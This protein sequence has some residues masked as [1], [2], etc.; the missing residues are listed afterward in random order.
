MHAV[1]ASFADPQL[2]EVLLRQ[3]TDHALLLIDARGRVLSWLMG[4][5]RVFGYSAA[6]MCGSRIDRLY[7][8]EDRARN[9]PAA[10]L[11]IALKSGRSENDRWML[12]KDGLRFWAVGVMIALRHESGELAGFAKILRDRTEIRGQIDA[13]ESRAEAHAQES[14]RKSLVL[15]TLAHE[16]RNP[17]GVLANVAHLMES[18]HPD[19]GKLAYAKRVLSRQTSYLTTLVEDLLDVSRIQAGKAELRLERVDLERLL[20][21]ALE[22]S[23]AALAEKRQK[24][25]FMHPQTPIVFAGDPTRLKQVFVNLISNASRYSEPGCRILVRSSTEGEEAVVRV[26][27]E[28]MGIPPELLPRIFDLFVQQPGNKLQAGGLGLG[29]SIVKEYVELHGGIVTVRSE[30][31]GHGSEFVVRLPLRRPAVAPA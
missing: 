19:D 15:G 14:E 9:V 10:E 4:S 31:V 7:T 21:D 28:G 5:E 2:I 22:V 30:G 8:H 13:L 26:E 12:R 11:E 23:S 1:A 18:L 25:E 17:L 29:L 27:D 20:G 24:V 6:E 3:A 16:L